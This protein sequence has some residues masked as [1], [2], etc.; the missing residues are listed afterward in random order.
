M[1][2]NTLLVVGAIIVLIIGAVVIVTMNNDPV[3]APANSTSTSSSQAQTAE[4]R[5]READFQAER[6]ESEA[7]ANEVAF[8]IDVSTLPEAQQTAL[9]VMGIN[10]SSTLNITNKMMTCVGTDMSG[11]RM[12]EIKGGASVTAGEGIKLVSCYNA[13]N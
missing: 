7:Q 2:N 5:Q 1:N 10:S 13:N 4:Q 9:A 8:T 3:G 11:T 6:A 12:A